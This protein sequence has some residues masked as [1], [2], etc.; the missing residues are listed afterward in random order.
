MYYNRLFGAYPT[1]NIYFNDIEK[2]KEMN[3]YLFPLIF[4]RNENNR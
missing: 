2:A 4:R 3:N 1:I